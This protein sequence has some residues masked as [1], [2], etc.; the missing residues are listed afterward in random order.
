MIDVIADGGVQRAAVRVGPGGARGRTGPGRAQAVVPERHGQRDTTRSLAPRFFERMSDADLAR[1]LPRR[2]RSR[3]P[4]QP[5]RALGDHPGAAGA[6][7][8]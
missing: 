6:R 7:A 3:V 8:A 5:R 1:D 4:A 2:G